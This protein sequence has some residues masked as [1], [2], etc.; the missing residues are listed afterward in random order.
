MRASSAS[1]TDPSVRLWDLVFPCTEPI[2][3]R[4]RFAYIHL[5]NLIAYSKRDRDGK[6]DA[7]LACFRPD[8]TILLFFL[9]GDLVN[10]A[11]ISTAGRYAIAIPE[12]LKHMK[13]EPERSELVFAKASEEQLAIMWASCTQTPLD[14]G[15]D[16][17]DTKAVFTNMLERKWSGTLELI[18]KGFVNYVIVKEG[19][20]QSGLFADPKKNERPQDTLAR[21]FT[22]PP[23]E[24]RPK[25]VIKAYTTIGQ[26]PHQAPPALVKVFREFV[27]SLSDAAERANPGDA[28][29]RAEKV[30]ARLVAEHDVLR[31]VGGARNSQT[32]DPIVEP[33]QLAEAVAAWTSE[34]LTELEVVNPGVAPRLLK[35]AGREPRFALGAAGFF[36]RLPWRIEW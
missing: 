21:I 18:S 29:T 9:E 2:V 12:A 7:Y 4:T 3:A 20:Y 17:T 8:E 35:E 22:A 14:L 24:P 27:W 1:L 5:D 26:V 32:A 25:V 16:S 10:A 11:V 33:T 28:A 19:H 31:C 30:R 34:F 13:A 6:V 23:P 36:D 15:I